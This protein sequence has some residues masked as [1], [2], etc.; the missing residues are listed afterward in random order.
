[1]KTATALHPETAIQLK[2]LGYNLSVAR[3]MKRLSVRALGELALVSASTVKRMELG[4]GSVCM[5][6]YAAALGALGL[7][8]HIGELGDVIG[9]NLAARKA[10]ES[11]PRRVRRSVVSD[12]VRTYASVEDWVAEQ[13]RARKTLR[14]E[15]VVEIWERQGGKCALSGHVLD[16]ND[17]G[18]GRPS[19]DRID[20]G[21]GYSPGN[22]QIVALAVNFLKNASSQAEARTF[23]AGIRKQK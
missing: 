11:L 5:G 12:R 22:I 18:M 20:S 21:Y 9:D 8:A 2:E 1:M 14:V 19:I 23:I 10:L 4:S 3:R 7:N 15:Q 13:V 6:A 17:N 16:V